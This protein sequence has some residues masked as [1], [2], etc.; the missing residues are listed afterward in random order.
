[1]THRVISTSGVPHRWLRDR[2][3]WWAALGFIAATVAAVAFGAFVLFQ[4][5]LALAEGQLQIPRKYSSSPVVIVS[6]TVAAP[7][8]YAF[9]LIYVAVG[10]ASI[11][12]AVSGVWRL[13]RATPAQRSIILMPPVPS[14]RRRP[15]RLLRSL[16]LFVAL[17]LFALV[18]I[19]FYRISKS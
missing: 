3:S 12:A 8:Y 15:I 10:V 19:V 7:I 16:L 11:S 9:L 4:A 6:P 14:R 18:I 13:W 1:M 5:F 2:V 17:P